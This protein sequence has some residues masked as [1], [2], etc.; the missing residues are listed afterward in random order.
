MSNPFSCPTVATCP[1]RIRSDQ[2]SQPLSRWTRPRQRW[3]RCLDTE[4]HRVGLQGERMVG[5]DRDFT[6]YLLTTWCLAEYACCLLSAQ[7]LQNTYFCHRQ[8]QLEAE[9]H[10]T[11]SFFLYVRTGSFIVQSLYSKYQVAI[12]TERQHRVLATSRML[13]QDGHI[14]RTGFISYSS[15]WI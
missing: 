8:K 5:N 12:S 9:G 6:A 3:V 10:S 7:R 14:P 4:Y 1:W 11:H 15:A 13:L 2:I